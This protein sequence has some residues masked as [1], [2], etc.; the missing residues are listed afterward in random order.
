MLLGARSWHKAPGSPKAYIPMQG[1]VGER[2]GYQKPSEVTF[3]QALDWSEPRVL[4]MGWG[5]GGGKHVAGGTVEVAGL[6]Y[7]KG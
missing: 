2:G 7:L 5:G 1:W 6:K 4:G 3:E